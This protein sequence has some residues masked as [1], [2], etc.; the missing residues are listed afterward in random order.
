MHSLIGRERYTLV[1]DGCRWRCGDDVILPRRNTDSV[2]N[3]AHIPKE[4]RDGTRR[5]FT[6]GPN[7]AGTASVPLGPLSDVAAILCADTGA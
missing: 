1:T 2:I 5:G 6:R 4:F 3:I 7:I